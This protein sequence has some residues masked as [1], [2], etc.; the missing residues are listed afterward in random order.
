MNV[1]P[2]E[3]V[4]REERRV[5]KLGMPWFHSD[6]P[7]WELKQVK[8][9]KL[10]WVTRAR[11]R[12]S[13]EGSSGR[14]ATVRTPWGYPWQAEQSV[15]IFQ[16][17]PKLRGGHLRD[18]SLLSLNDMVLS[19]E[20]IWKT[21]QTSNNN[22]TSS[23][24]TFLVSVL[25]QDPGSLIRRLLSMLGADS[26]WGD[27]ECLRTNPDTSW[28]PSLPYFHSVSQHPRES[29]DP[30]Y[31]PGKESL[32]AQNCRYSLKWKVDQGTNSATIGL[33]ILHCSC[34]FRAGLQWKDSPQLRTRD[35]LPGV[36]HSN[37]IHAFRCDQE[38][39][40]G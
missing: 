1:F 11:Q 31:S 9:G 19:G 7:G 39:F 6:I 27:R 30:L 18:E 36:G 35:R 4:R 2:G 23:H 17:L 8:T 26:R 15:N 14:R 40:S 37:G 38:I 16:P 33:I 29:A 34:L 21:N 32:R 25:N 22:R 20:S 10:C 3:V 28:I 5:R 12:M 13:Q 24:T